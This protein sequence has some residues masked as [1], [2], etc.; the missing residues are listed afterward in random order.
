MTEDGELVGLLEQILL[1]LQFQN[2]QHLKTLLSEV[3]ITEADRRIYELSD[4]S[5]SQQE[6]ADGAS[7]SQ[8]NIS[9]KW[10]AWRPLGIVHDLPDQPGR[11]RHL[12]SLASL[13][14][15]TTQAKEG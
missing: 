9:A 10:K 6:I 5:K 11:C 4:G 2:R 8:P 12:A 3:L 14:L 7:V 15:H 13:G 1:W